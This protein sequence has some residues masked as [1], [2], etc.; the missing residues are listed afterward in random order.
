M[1]GIVTK[2]DLKWKK[3]D[4]TWLGLDVSK[5]GVKAE[6]YAH[7]YRFD[8]KAGRLLDSKLEMDV[9]LM[10]TL[11]PVGMPIEMNMRLR[12]TVTTTITDKHPFKN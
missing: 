4:E 11:G 7:A 12:K 1:A 9:S 8:M 5:A 6:K 10:V 2:G 3:G